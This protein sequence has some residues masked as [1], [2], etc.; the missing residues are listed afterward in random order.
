MLIFSL[1]QQREDLLSRLAVSWLWRSRHHRPEGQGDEE[2]GGGVP[3]NL[4]CPE[5]LAA[6]LAQAPRREAAARPKPR[7]AAAILS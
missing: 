2:E 3:R 5:E 6:L 4:P 1:R 7:D